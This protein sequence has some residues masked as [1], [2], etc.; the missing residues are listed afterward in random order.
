[1]S[2]RKTSGKKAG[3][4][5]PRRKRRVPVLP[6][7]M[8]PTMAYMIDGELR[9][10]KE[11]RREIEDIVDRPGSMDDETIDPFIKAF[12]EGL[13]TCRDKHEQL[14]AWNAM[15]GLTGEQRLAVERLLRENENLREETERVLDLGRRIRKQTINRILE[16]D[17]LELGIEG[18][19]GKHD[20]VLYEAGEQQDPPSFL[21]QMFPPRPQ[22]NRGEPPAPG[23]DIIEQIAG[24]YHLS[25]QCSSH[26]ASALGWG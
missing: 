9:D 24:S 12:E 14:Q 21:E 3:R 11:A 26:S 25:A 16:K 7:S 5:S 20:D 4:N 17:P 23:I 15:P 22:D 1:M 13:A 10:T 6:L 18:L 19:L 2:R 8:L